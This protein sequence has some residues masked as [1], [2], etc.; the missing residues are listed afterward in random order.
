MEIVAHHNMQYIGR[1]V[2]E[3]SFDAVSALV[4][5]NSRLARL[6]DHLPGMAYRCR[7]VARGRW[8]LEFVSAGCV[9]LTGRHPDE[10]LDSHRDAF[11]DWIHPED[12]PDIAAQ[13]EA[14]LCDRQP[15]RCVYR[16][17]AAD[18]TQKWVRD[19][20]VGVWS[21]TGDVQ[22]CEGFITDISA[23]KQRAGIL[24][25]SE[26]QVERLLASIQDG[27]VLIKGAH[28]Q[29]VNATLATMVGYP[30]ETLVGMDY[31][32]FI[33]PAD[34]AKLRGYYRDQRDGSDAVTEHATHLLHRDGVT[35]VPV[36]ICVVP[37]NF[38]GSG[39]L[40]TIK[41]MSIARRAEAERI[42]LLERVQQQQSA[43]IQ[44]STHPA[45]AEGRL[46]EALSLIA[47]VAARTLGVELVS[48]WKIG[49]DN[50]ELQCLVNYRLSAGTLSPNERLQ[51]SQYPAYFAAMQEG[52][53]LDVA[54]V[55]SD[56]RTAA[57]TEVYWNPLGIH[58]TL[59]A[60]VRVHGK[61]IGMVCHEHV[62]PCREWLSDEIAF[63][64][65]IADLVA[66]ALLNAHIRRRTE[67][68]TAITR[69]GQEISARS[70][71]QQ[72]LDSIAHH[73]AELSD[74]DICSVFTMHPDGEVVLASYGLTPEY[75][76]AIA[77]VGDAFL[78]EG[79]IG[80]ALSERRP[81][82]VYADEAASGSALQEVMAHDGIQAVLIVP[83]VEEDEIVGGIVLAHRQPWH[84]TAAEVDFIQAL[85]QQSANAVANVRLLELERNARKRAETLYR[86]TRSLITFDN[87][88]DLLRA[89]VDGV[90]EALD[91]PWVVLSTF[92]VATRQILDYVPGGQDADPDVRLSFDELWEGLGESFRRTGVAALLTRECLG[93]TA[94]AW[95][96]YQRFEH[97]LSSAIVAPLQYQNVAVGILLALRPTGKPAFA[98]HDVALIAAMANQTAAAIENFLLLDTLNREKTQLGLVYRL[99]QHLSKSLD[100]HDVCRLALDEICTALGSLHG[101]LFIVDAESE[102]MQLMAHRGYDADV[103]HALVQDFRVGKGLSG[104]VAQHRQAAVVDDVN[105]DPRWI[106][107]SNTSEI[108]SALSVPLFSGDELLGVMTLGST[109]RA[110][111]TAEY[112]WLVESAAV[113]VAIAL[114]NARLFDKIRQRAR[115]QEWVSNMARVL[116]TLD[117]QRAFPV[118]ARG[119]SGLAECEYIVLTLY[120]EARR[121]FAAIESTFPAL[122]AGSALLLPRDINA[123]IVSG[124]PHVT[125]DLAA[126]PDDPLLCEL[127]ALGA[128]SRVLLPLLVGTEVT[129]LLYLG[130]RQA[131]TAAQITTLQQIADMVAI[132]VENDRLFR[133]EQRQRMV[134]ER[135]QETALVVNTLDLQ[136]VLTLIMDQLES[137]FP[138]DSGSIQILEQDV[139]RVI[140]ARNSPYA[141]I[142]S[143]FPL[144][145]YPYNRRLAAGEVVTIEDIQQND[146]GWVPF[147]AALYL[148][149]N[150]GVPLW[151][152]DKVIGAL[153]IDNRGVRVYTDED[154]RVV[155]VFAQQA[156]IAIENARLFEAQRVQ[157]ELAEALEAAAAVVSSVLNFD[158]VL[159]YILDQVARVV[160]GDI[161]NII[162]IEGQTGRMI[163]WRGY[164]EHGIPSTP[165]A[166]ANIPIMTYPSLVQMIKEARPVVM[167]DIQHDPRWVRVPGQEKLGAYVAAPIRIAG[168][169]EGFINV[170]GLS[171]GQFDEQD[172][173]RLQAFA[174]HASIALHNAR[175]FQQ[176][177]Q[178]AEELE[179]RVRDRTI[180]LE[181]KNAWLEAILSGTADGIVVT[182]SDGQIVDAN[183]VARLWLYHS[184]PAQ[185]VERLRATI[186]DL[187][188]QAD[189]HPDAVLELTGLDL[190]LSA[191]SIFGQGVEGPAVVVAVHDVS[192]LK[193]LDRVK[194]QFVSNV[195][196]EL[197]TPLAS[198]RLYSS[199]LQRN[200]HE[201]RQRYFEALDHEVVRLSK[202]V[203]DILQIS[204]IEAGQLELDRRIMDL[205]TLTEMAVM[206][207]KVL[208]ESR[209]LTI[210]YHTAEGKIAVSADHDRFVQVLNNLIEN[211]INYTSAGGEIAVSTERRIKD[212]R[213]WGT[214]TVADT[215]M[216]IPEHEVQHLFERFFR[217]SEPQDLRIQGS[218]LGLAIV[219]EIVE[220]HGG[221][222]TVES[223][224]GVGSTF[225]VW[226]PL[227]DT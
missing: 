26:E 193:A 179:R 1:A 155:R 117:L 32:A 172:A 86:L 91:A 194:S 33:D 73:A 152:R 207:H 170:S 68:L 16:L 214:V 85:A 188:L 12:Y 23:E 46:T 78:F 102:A 220:L 110:F 81:I 173:E 72:I 139:M 39:V 106:K 52:F 37:V 142:G 3:S 114:Y 128:R 47:E 158:Q 5:E 43:V 94:A 108:Q 21:E 80:Q 25:H 160:H 74:A 166:R 226:M 130:S 154:I 14:A 123:Q 61:V 127:R 56:P 104:W 167:A 40:A 225:T 190:E 95:S 31:S 132:A 148:R 11:M 205:N 99:G 10:W 59:E 79:A 223:Q 219:K 199:L 187:A 181:A 83:M 182:D 49:L 175:L 145:D 60:P 171:A 111:F 118:L 116:N 58:S 212:N 124:Q 209:N 24:I 176:T 54:D 200:S 77:D 45:V 161:F 135:L 101:L 48:I 76:K 157:R 44:L 105:T 88:P 147:N 197:R 34:A 221:N 196:H 27:V 6:L 121:V 87:L 64:R 180:E 20:G 18:G 89:V 71:L 65:Q 185:D 7:Y 17:L 140:A 153:T 109:Q 162:L 92:D 163:R 143:C 29:F 151:V 186:R 8:T 183:R 69:V 137:I 22:F 93:T 30:A 146:M 67:E 62:G 126:Q 195:S 211:A 206:S 218:G 201:N 115:E 120:D 208:A 107:T 15:Y 53:V 169:T 113:T 144:K 36:N 100:P 131:L 215:G 159:D 133:A 165:E 168:K 4:E 150:L 149:S 204:R 189:S 224:V 50:S 222:V 198:I 42:Q 138:Y 119:L 28:I 203:E 125:L 141:P 177:V 136:E 55:R 19:Q 122:P 217:G 84:F 210:T 103:L 90:A 174:D 216:G 129:G 2:S 51:V 57:L 156:A 164:E 98:E 227:M 75:V 82:Q 213:S 192:Y 9:A 202:L 184:L 191:S 38:H 13:M 63:A 97:Y 66:Q 35:R 134:A 70:N 112:R 96:F 178:H 41:D